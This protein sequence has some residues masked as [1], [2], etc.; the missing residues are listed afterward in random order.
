VSLAA[1]Q[2][3]SHVAGRPALAEKMLLYVGRLHPKKQLPSL[4]RAWKE[5]EQLEIAGRD[6]WDL[7]IVG[8]DQSDHREDLLGLIRDL[9]IARVHVCGPVFGED[10]SA[11]LFSASGLILPSISEGLPMV[12]LEAWAHRLPVIMTDS[13]N[14]PDG[15]RR[16]AALRITTEAADISRGMAELIQM[17]EADR[18]QMGDRGLRLVRQKFAWPTFAS[19]MLAVYE[20]L[21]GGGP[22]PP[23]V[24]A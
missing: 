10:L 22:T 9:K 18:N 20:W 14:L 15:F 21:L 2:S 24:V 8:W 19:Q 7:V 11:L 13:C 23:T 12:V 6:D 5:L 17:S 16:G 4:L 3:S 1:R